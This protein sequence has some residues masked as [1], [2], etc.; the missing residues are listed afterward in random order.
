M[1]TRT[2]RCCRILRRGLAAAFALLCGALAPSQTQPAVAAGKVAPELLRRATTAARLRVFVVLGEQPQ[3]EIL[4]RIEAASQRRMDL[5]EANYLEAA[6][7][8]LV[9]EET[10]ARR[11]D[12]VEALILENRQAAAREIELRIRPAQELAMRRRAGLG[13][14][15]LRRYL[16][17]NMVLA[18]IPTAAPPALE[19]DPEVAAVLPVGE[20]T[21]HLDVSARVIGAPALWDRGYTGAGHSVAVL[22]TGINLSH[23][24]FSG[25]HIVS[26]VFLQHGADNSCF[27]DDASSA[28]DRQGHGTAVAGV[29]AAVGK[30][31]G[32]LYNL[33]L[34]FKR[35][36]PPG[37]C[38]GGAASNGADVMDALEWAVFNTPARIFNR[39]Y[40]SATDSDYPPT[41]R[42]L[43]G[44]ADQYG[45]L[46]VLPAGNSG[47]DSFTLD[48][49]ACAY[50][51]LSVAAFDDRNTIDSSDDLIAPFSS[52]GPTR[53]GRHKPDVAAPGFKIWAPGRA[54]NEYRDTYGTSVAAPHVAGA[55][56]LLRHSGVTAALALKAVLINTAEARRWN[57]EWGWGGINLNRAAAGGS[58]YDAALAPSSREGSYRL[59]RGRAAFDFKATLVWNRHDAFSAADSMAW[60]WLYLRDTQKGARASIE[61]IAPDGSVYAADS[62]APLESGSD[63]CFW[64]GLE[65][66][67][68]RPASLPGDW[69][70]SIRYEGSLIFTL[71]FKIAV[72]FTLEKSLT[73]RTAPSGSVCTEPDPVTTFARTDSRVYVWFY[74]ARAKAGPRVAVQFYLPAGELHYTVDWPPLEKDGNWCYRASMSV[75]NTAA[76]DMFGDWQAKIRWDDQVIGAL[77]F[78]IVPVYVVDHKM[79][80]TVP[81]QY[82]PEA[83]EPASAFLT[84]DERVWLWFYLRGTREGDRVRA[85]WYRP[86]GELYRIGNWTLGAT[87]GGTCFRGSTPLAG[88]AAGY[89][90]AWTISVFYNDEYLFPGAFT[91]EPPPEPGSAP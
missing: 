62:W 5:A 38:D 51:V 60:V 63:R 39:S 57:S 6:H 46:L 32:T 41:A 42:L 44:V 29:V 75:V 35:R 23:P 73:A 50:N 11:R 67:G 14:A 52:R 19:A 53:A 82:C 70:V 47:P 69:K 85:E 43:D 76:A 45:I 31:L 34:A 54:G 74:A 13:A 56:A 72:G 77:P 78:R 28:E 20:H 22:D 58:H 88:T 86:D 37:P 4:R 55:A 66:A 81:D 40:G 7:Q 64:W 91:V 26:R 87:S 12:R 27:A 79:A 71:P 3:S 1:G 18:E 61:W 48:G 83:P 36:E 84:T 17:V 25:R 68:K 8:L 80:K 9:S 10:L 49:G 65:I 59:Y 24:F 15:R 89:P 33:K 21:A 2:G 16:V 30:G 90:G